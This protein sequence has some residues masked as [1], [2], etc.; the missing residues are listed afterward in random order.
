[1]CPRG[2]TRS[3]DNQALCFVSSYY[4]R[5]TANTHIFGRKDRQADTR[6]ARL[7]RV[8]RLRLA[9]ESEACVVCSASKTSNKQTDRYVYKQIGPP[10][11]AYCTRLTVLYVAVHTALLTWP[12]GDTERMWRYQSKTPLALALQTATL[13]LATAAEPTARSAALAVNGMDLME[14]VVTHFVCIA[15][16]TA[17][18]RRVPRFDRL[19]G[20]QQERLS[21]RRSESMLCVV[22][23]SPLR[24][25]F[26][27]DLSKEP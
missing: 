24:V 2:F 20:G 9:S 6:T 16:A 11:I 3:I 25:G 26:H 5:Y 15:T 12:A 23:R 7:H 27:V 18:Q 4:S 19:Y 22:F 14:I 1:M 10:K 17:E 21:P 8:Q 13:S